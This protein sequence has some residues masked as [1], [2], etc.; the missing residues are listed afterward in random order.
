MNNNED[1]SELGETICSLWFLDFTT[2]LPHSC[3]DG[4][5]ELLFKMYCITSSS[6]I[7]KPSPLMVFI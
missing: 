2:T 5:V 1:L 6:Q 4:K 3:L 7:L